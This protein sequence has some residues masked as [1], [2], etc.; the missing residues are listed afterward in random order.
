MQ[1]RWHC[2]ILHVGSLHIHARRCNTRREMCYRL[3]GWRSGI[4]LAVS[5]SHSGIMS[6]L[7]LQTSAADQ[8]SRAMWYK[9]LYMVVGRDVLMQYQNSLNTVRAW[10][11]CQQLRTG[12]PGCVENCLLVCVGPARSYEQATSW[13]ALWRFCASQQ[14]VWWQSWTAAHGCLMA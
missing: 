5:A 12:G 2:S 7:L 8:E 13:V 14:Q 4:F 11:L 9:R 10:L 3:W 6:V 1:E